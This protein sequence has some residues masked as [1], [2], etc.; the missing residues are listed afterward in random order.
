[1]GLTSRGF[2][3]FCVLLVV[4]APLGTLFF[5]SRLKGPR[6]ARIG[7]RLAMIGL[8]QVTA[9]ALVATMVNNAYF[10]Y[11]SWSDLLGTAKVVTQASKG[12]LPSG[13]AA[14]QRRIAAAGHGHSAAVAGVVLSQTITS[15]RT[16]LGANALIYLPPQYFQP[17]YAHTRFP[18][19]M[20]MPGYPGAPQI[21]TT[22]LP[23]PQV[24]MSEV[25]A[26]RAQPFIAVIIDETVLPPRDT[27]CTNVV[28]GPQVMTFL[29]KEVRS[30]LSQVL[31]TR[32]DRNGWAMMGDSTGGFCAVKMVMDNPTLYGS[33]VGI[34]AYYTALHD[35]TT[36]SLFGGST[37][38]ADQN[39]PLWRLQHLPAPPV[40][41]LATI[42][43][44]ERTYPQTVAFIRAAR[45]P[46]TVNSIVATSGGHNY[47]NWRA[48]L[49]QAIDWLSR[50]F[51]IASSSQPPPAGAFAAAAPHRVKK[52]GP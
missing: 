47:R 52:S 14:E 34:S 23:V 39:S 18:V 16:G 45:A 17:R 37:R 48:M 51:A 32:T 38:V 21:Y 30:Q 5:W 40:A 29:A 46:M 24:M 43:A 1:M 15:P 22:R 25:R 26:G 2:L 4:G 50:R 7:Q 19:A 44:Q 11:A 27:E 28:H 12:T 33:A 13:P 8:C 6:A 20:V 9:L 35:S 36:G 3:A 10:F 41:V 42:S 31:R 49:P